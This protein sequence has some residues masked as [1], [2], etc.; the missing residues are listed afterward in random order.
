MSLFVV[1]GPTQSHCELWCQGKGRPTN[2]ATWEMWYDVL[3][4]SGPALCLSIDCN[5]EQIQKK[6]G[7]LIDVL[8]TN[9]IRVFFYFITFKKISVKDTV[10]LFCWCAFCHNPYSHM[11]G[12]ISSNSHWLCVLTQLYMI[13]ISWWAWRSQLVVGLCIWAVLRERDL[14]IHPHLLH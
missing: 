7:D 6:T 11:S 3:L 12:Y 14:I 5:Y 10:E 4:K 13:T 1:W 8:T 9:T 2:W